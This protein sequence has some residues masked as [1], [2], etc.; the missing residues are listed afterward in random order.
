MKLARK[1]QEECLQ[2]DLSYFVSSGMQKF[3]TQYLFKTVLP[4]SA[5]CYRLSVMLL[6]FVHKFVYF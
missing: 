5:L 4:C 2:N 6:S 3:L 1:S